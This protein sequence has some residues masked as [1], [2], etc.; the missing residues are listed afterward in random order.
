M[1][2]KAIELFLVLSELGKK[3]S[4]GD[5]WKLFFDS[6]GELASFLADF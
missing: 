4:Q 2:N 1:F 6:L 3:F 5:V